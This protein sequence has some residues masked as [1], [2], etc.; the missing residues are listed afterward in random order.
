MHSC[1]GGSLSLGLPQLLEV[2]HSKAQGRAHIKGALC[3]SISWLFG[4][5]FIMSSKLHN[6]YVQERWFRE[7]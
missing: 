7:K 4:T 6:N 3:A 5:E 1:S 2:K